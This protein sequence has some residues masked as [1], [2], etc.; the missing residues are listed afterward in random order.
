MLSEL[1]K[2]KNDAIKDNESVNEEKSQNLNIEN[3]QNIQ[4]DKENINFS[5][6]NTN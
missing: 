3:H 4:L 2:L 1:E 6:C 5:E